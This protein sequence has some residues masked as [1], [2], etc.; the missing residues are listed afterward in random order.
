MK[1]SLSF[2]T[3]HTINIETYLLVV[4]LTLVFDFD[5][6]LIIESPQLTTP[7]LFVML[8][9]RNRYKSSLNLGLYAFS[10]SEH[11]LGLI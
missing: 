4:E 9:V 11:T 7:P 1:F 8:N 10:G 5:R 6:R 3:L 2:T